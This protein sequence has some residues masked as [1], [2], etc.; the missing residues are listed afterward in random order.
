MA[1]DH[2]YGA[3]G[4]D[5]WAKLSAGDSAYLRA[6][7]PDTS[8]HPDPVIQRV[9][10]GDMFH[11]VQFAQ[12]LGVVHHTSD[13]IPAVHKNPMAWYG[14]QYVTRHPDHIGFDATGLE[15]QE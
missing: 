14:N 5:D 13:E 3:I 4:P 15:A 6:E 7:A 9:S 11:P 1:N 12:V 10:S 2:N 8:R